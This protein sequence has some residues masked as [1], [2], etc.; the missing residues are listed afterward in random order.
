MDL[1][2]KRYASPFLLLD[3]MI[4]ASSFAHFVAELMRIINEEKEWEVWMHRAKDKTYDEFK[5][6][7]NSPSITPKE[8]INESDLE[9]IV[10]DSSSILNNFKPS[11]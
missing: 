4:Q 7:I 2:F 6:A 10:K 9:A 5:R 8:E 11:E 1:L 3:G